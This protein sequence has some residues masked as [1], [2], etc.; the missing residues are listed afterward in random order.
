MKRRGSQIALLGL[1]GLLAIVSADSWVR[2]MGNGIAYGGLVGL[3]GHEQA[4]AAYGSR[5]IRFLEI[6]VCSEAL[7]IV[8][9]SWVITS[10][11]GSVWRRLCIALVWATAANVCTYAVVHG[12]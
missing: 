1:A 10:T 3:P 2:Y 5:A 4:L 11:R 9:V 6:A 7:A 12:L 8:A